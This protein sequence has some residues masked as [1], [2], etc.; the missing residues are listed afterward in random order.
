MSA[1]FS[2]HSSRLGTK[3][4]AVIRLMPMPLA[5]A[6]PMS[7][8]RPKRMST[9]ARK[10]ITVVRP[11]DNM[12]AVDLLRASAMASPSSRPAARHSSNRCSRNTE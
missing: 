10:P 1:S 2:V 7:R 5:R 8:P 9:R 3:K 4:N 6:R 11:L 12:E